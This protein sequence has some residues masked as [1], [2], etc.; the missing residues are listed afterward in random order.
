MIS[1]SEYNNLPP[2]LSNLSVCPVST[3][4]I[5]ES[6]PYLHSNYI[7]HLKNHSWCWLPMGAS[8]VKVRTFRIWSKEIQKPQCVCEWED[9][10]WWKQS[11]CILPNRDA[12]DTDLIAD[13]DSLMHLTTLTKALIAHNGGRAFH[14]QRIYLTSASVFLSGCSQLFIQLLAGLSQ[15]SI[16]F[17][18]TGFQ[19][20]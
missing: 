18:C 20:C 15:S 9:T 11:V 10:D 3:A 13:C 1:T 4:K 8:R 12:D 14:P 2:H 6:L 5:N 17:W 7:D 19:C 16:Y